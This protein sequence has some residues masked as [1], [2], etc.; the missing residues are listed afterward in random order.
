M[1]SLPDGKFQPS[2]RVSTAMPS[3]C[4]REASWA[5]SPSQDMNQRSPCDAAIVPWS[6]WENRSPAG[7]VPSPSVTHGLAGSVLAAAQ[8]TRAS[9]GQA[10]ASVGSAEE[11]SGRTS[12]PLLRAGGVVEEAAR[13]VAGE[14]VHRLVARGDDAGDV[15][16]GAEDVLVRRAAGP[17]AA[18]DG[19]GSRGADR[20][21]GEDAALDPVRRERRVTALERS[22]KPL[23]GFG[24]AMATDDAATLSASAAAAA[25]IRLR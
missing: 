8:G 13:G 6:G 2:A 17:D 9:S 7:S 19:R 21:V 23:P 10:A 4:A 15:D 12:V 11:N 25:R 20:P 22:L 14:A 3:G 18:A 5:G 1:S 24:L 16:A